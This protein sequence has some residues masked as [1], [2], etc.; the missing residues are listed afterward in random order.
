MLTCFGRANASPSSCHSM[1]VEVI[2]Q[3][4]GISSVF[5]WVGSE[6]WTQ[7]IRFCCKCL[8]TLAHLIGPFYT[9]AHLTGP[10]Y[11]LAHLTGPFYTLPHLTGPFY[12]LAPSHWSI[13]HTHTSH[14]PILHTRTI[15]LAQEAYFE[16]D[17]FKLVLYLTITNSKWS[18]GCWGG[19][20]KVV[21]KGLGSLNPSL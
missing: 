5:H 13:L 9:L 3:F 11:T 20:S 10:F 16:I 6:A 2:G 8:C 1:D 18:P 12:T 15:S 14:W 17:V 19:W 7:V 4:W 21:A